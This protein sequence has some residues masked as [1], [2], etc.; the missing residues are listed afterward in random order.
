M[1]H[2]RRVY[3]TWLEGLNSYLGL[4]LGYNPIRELP[5]LA[6]AQST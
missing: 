2:S 1:E 4:V 5:T 3:S 6:S